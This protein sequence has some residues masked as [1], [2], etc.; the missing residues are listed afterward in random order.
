[1]VEPLHDREGFFKYYDAETAKLTLRSVSRLWSSPSRFNDPFDNQ[2][3]L[4]FEEATKELAAKNLDRFHQIL[5][6]PTPFKADQ[7][8]ADT[9]KME[10]LRQTFVQYP[11]FAFTEEDMAE[12]LDGEMEGMKRASKSAE[13]TAGEIRRI[14]SDISIFCMSETHDN[15]LMWSH[16]AGNHSGAVVNFLSLRE[17]HSPLMMAQPVRYSKDM[18]RLKFVSLMD[19]EG[20][21]RDVLETITLSKSDAWAYEKE[22]RVVTTIRDKS[23]N[24]EIIPYAREEVGAVYLG[25]NMSKSDRKEIVDITRRRFPQAKIY[26]AEKHPHEF[27]LM[28]A[29]V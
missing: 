14:L 9:P 27:A 7:F 8:G 26:Q 1:M 21:K 24:Y 19:L 12:L 29:E 17:V 15:L 10:Q 3:D 5:R 6:S 16:Y 20:A 23:A 22:W 18:P 13:E 11:D 25:C 28:F 2:F 4:R